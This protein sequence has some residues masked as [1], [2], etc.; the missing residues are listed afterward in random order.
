MKK[1][2][3]RV[4]PQMGE[5][6]GTT[7]NNMKIVERLANWLFGEHEEDRLY[8]GNKYPGSKQELAARAN[9]QAVVDKAYPWMKLIPHSSNGLEIKPGGVYPWDEPYEDVFYAPKP[10]QKR[11]PRYVSRRAV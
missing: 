4:Y 1:F 3:N 9:A 8:P 5:D 6:L 2:G 10:P 7:G 11:L